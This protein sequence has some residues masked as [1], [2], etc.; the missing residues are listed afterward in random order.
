MY[1]REPTPQSLI[2]CPHGAHSL[3][4]PSSSLHFLVSHQALTSSPPSGASR[5][6]PTPEAGSLGILVSHGAVFSG[7]RPTFSPLR[8]LWV[9]FSAF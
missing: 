8:S 3:S 4:W 6:W 7:P 1:V 2:S 9:I 5:R